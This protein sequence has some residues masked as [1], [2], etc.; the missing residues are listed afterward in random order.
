M[1]SESFRLSFSLGNI[2]MC[3]ETEIMYMSHACMIHL[4]HTKTY[5]HTVQTAWEGLCHPSRL[6]QHFFFYQPNIWNQSRWVKQLPKL[7]RDGK[8]RKYKY[9]RMAFIGIVLPCLLSYT[10]HNG[11]CKCAYIQFL[12]CQNQPFIC[13]LQFS[14]YC[15]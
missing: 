14:Y 10:P 15:Y 8:V 2:Q 3:V 5:L 6:N 12:Q 1:T 13:P 4:C 11:Q 7:S 9:T